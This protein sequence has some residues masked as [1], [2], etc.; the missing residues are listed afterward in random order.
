MPG[1]YVDLSKGF[2][3]QANNSVDTLANIEHVKGGAN[4]DTIIGNASDNWLTG[5]GGA[6]RIDGGDGFDT[7]SYFYSTAGVNVSLAA[8]ATTGGGDAQG[9]VLRNMENLQGSA[10]NDTLTGDA[11]DNW[12]Y[13]EA[14]ADILDGGA[15]VDGASYFYSTAGVNV[16]LVAG[17]TNTGGDA[18]GDVLT[19]IES[20][21]GS[22]FND[23]LT[24]NAG[25]NWFDGD[26]GADTING[27][28]GTDTVSYFYSTAAVRVS[29][30]AGASNTG[31]SAQGDVLSNI[32]N[33]EGSDFNDTLTG[34]GNN[35][36]FWGGAGADTINGGAGTDTAS[37][38][39]STDGVGVS[40]MA[41]ASNS[42]GEAQGDVLSNIENLEGSDFG[43]TLTGNA[44][45]NVLTGRAGDDW[46]Y[47]RGGADTLDGGDGFDWS[48]YFYSTTGVNVSLVA[49][50]TNT[51]GEAA[52]D[53]LTNIENLDGSN[54][55]DTLTGDAGDN[56]LEGEGG[57]DTLNGGA[58]IDT[59]SYF[60]STS[61]V[62]VS[63]VAFAAGGAKVC[64]GCRARQLS[65]AA[66][67]S[68]SQPPW[69]APSAA[70]CACRR[71]PA[72]ECVRRV[73]SA[74]WQFRRAG[75]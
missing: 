67:R 66:S 47:G 9:D 52:G 22:A 45:N 6:D 72:H 3:R 61:L 30:V 50:A 1:V 43:D 57:A 48:S 75:R 26:D 27:G 71:P 7:A 68:F 12:L 40:L 41:G 16:S 36:K 35:N 59:A 49:G 44:S 70:E 42:G 24:G 21:H 54:L 17:A 69:R 37:Y 51:G 11:G 60:Y 5:G 25:D 39:Y 18:Q 13:G 8:G 58:G 74:A 55:A 32:E 38:F 46:L 65:P 62:Q 23:T 73:P 53:V 64:Q 29:L 63:L 15:G 33:L 20:L 4:S 34:D 2:A 14:G 10:Y 31:G 19:S 56:W 28:A